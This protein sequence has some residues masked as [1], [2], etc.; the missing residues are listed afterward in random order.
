VPDPFLALKEGW[1]LRRLSPFCSR[2]ELSQLPR[3]RDAEKL[4]HATGWELAN[5]HLGTKRAA[6]PVR[7]DLSKRKSDWLCHATEIMTDATLKDWK[8]WRKTAS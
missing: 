2:I 1:V 3:T 8:E 6:A 4:F 5:V 7:R